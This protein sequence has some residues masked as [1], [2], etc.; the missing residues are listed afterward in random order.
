MYASV[1]SDSAIS[2]PR[3]VG[4]GLTAEISVSAVR[5]NL[6]LLRRLL[7]PDTKLCAVVKADCY[8]HGLETLL[9]VISEAADQLAVAT[10]KE[11]LQLRGMGCKR[12]ILMLFS[13]GACAGGDVLGELIAHGVTLT[14]TALPEVELLAK[15]ARRAGAEADV[16]VKVDTGMG[17]SGV[18]PEGAP[19]LIGQIR[20]EPN[21]KLTGLYTHLACADE[22][23]KASARRQLQ[24]FERAI[25][26]CGGPAGLTLHAANSAA[27]I[28]LPESHLAMIRPGIAV[29]GYQPS[30]AMQNV[31]PFRPAMRLCGRLMQ[32]KNIPAGSRCGYG[33]T[34]TFQ[35]PSRTGLVPVGYADGYLRSLSN[36]ATMRIGGR[37]VPVRGRISMDQTIVDL[38]DLPDAR[39]GDEVEII[40]PAP[41]AGHSV[42]NLARLA[43]TIP[44]EITTRL[45]RRIRRVPVE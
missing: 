6:S 4:G 33:L 19:A 26:A 17:R 36:K 1:P 37:D 7:R 32:V 31:L 8:G 16:H 43:G 18:M 11:A 14:V 2:M 15:A 34:Y 12:P 42:E 13:A 41:A 24:C 21:V 29:Y 35:R 9:D 39:V 28:D 5:Q 23:D 38:T 22:A 20:R 3:P 44:Y 45:S 40:S 10:A 27:A 25:A 30:D